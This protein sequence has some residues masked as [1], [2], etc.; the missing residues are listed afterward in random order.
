MDAAREWLLGAV[1][2]GLEVGCGV[3][4]VIR[5]RR[6]AELAPSA[7]GGGDPQDLFRFAAD[8]IDPTTGKPGSFAPTG[9]VPRLLERMRARG[10]TMDI[11][12]FQRA[13][14]R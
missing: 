7:D 12:A 3:D 14:R 5:V 10:V 8:A 9:V 1:D 11:G 6:I 2:V 4:G 13:A